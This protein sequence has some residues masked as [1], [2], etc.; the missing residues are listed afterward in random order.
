MVPSCCVNQAEKSGSSLLCCGELKFGM[1]AT[2]SKVSCS[3]VN[4]PGSSAVPVD[5]RKIAAQEEVR[6]CEFASLVKV[7]SCDHELSCSCLLRL[8]SLQDFSSLL[9]LILLI[10]YPCSKGTFEKKI[11]IAM[12]QSSAGVRLQAARGG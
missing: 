12:V 2:V 4:L 8:C 3:A 9:G 10:P 1:P 11:L 6:T 5:D 7:P